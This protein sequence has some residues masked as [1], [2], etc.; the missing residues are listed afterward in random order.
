MPADTRLSWQAFAWKRHSQAWPRRSVMRMSV[1]EVLRVAAHRKVTVILR[2]NSWWN[3]R[4]WNIRRVAMKTWIR[5]SFR[6][7]DRRSSRFIRALVSK[8][9][10]AQ[11]K[12]AWTYLSL[13]IVLKAMQRVKR[14]NKTSRLQSWIQPEALAKALVRNRAQRIHHPRQ[15]PRS[16]FKKIL[17]KRPT[18][19]TLCH[20][21]LSMNSL[22]VNSTRLPWAIV[23]STKLEARPI[24]TKWSAIVNKLTRSSGRPRRRN[25]PCLAWWDSQ[26]RMPNRWTW[27]PSLTSQTTECLPKSC[28]RRLRQLQ[29]RTKPILICFN[30]A[31]QVALLPKN[32]IV[33]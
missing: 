14:C 26:A 7:R 17:R 29:A 3:H 33:A 6:C 19:T 9:K 28:I 12:Q 21:S 8:I 25:R 1:R 15:R 13:K 27:Q 32:S 22:I 20:L 23:K 24:S 18:T 4:Q 31:L 30:G 11:V 5:K 16:Y 2:M 10:S